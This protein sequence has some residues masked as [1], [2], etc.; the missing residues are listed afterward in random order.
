MQ[1]QI[2]KLIFI[3]HERASTLN[4]RYDYTAISSTFN[5]ILFI[6]LDSCF[7]SERFYSDTN[8]NYLKKLNKL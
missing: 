6:S 8:L 4:S 7:S 1:G 3:S 5:F 2:F